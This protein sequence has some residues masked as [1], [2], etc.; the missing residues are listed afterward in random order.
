MGSSPRRRDRSTP[1]PHHLPLVQM[2]ENKDVV[3]TPG[4]AVSSPF[5]AEAMSAGVRGTGK[6]AGK[7]GR[8]RRQMPLPGTGA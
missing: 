4:K 6:E 3:R 7:S 1:N 8:Q 2:F 5:E